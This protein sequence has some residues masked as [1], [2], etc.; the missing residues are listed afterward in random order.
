MN[1]AE[2]KPDFE[3]AVS[4]LRQ[5]LT[6]IT[7]G[8]ADPSLLER[9]TVTAYDASMKLQEVA[10]ITV[11]EPRVL[12]IEPW[13]KSLVKDIG[14]ALKAANLDGQIQISGDGIRFIIPQMTEESRK[15]YVK[16]VGEKVEKARIAVR[17]VRDKIKEKINKE[18]KTKEISED[19]KFTQLKQ[20]DELAGEY[21]AQIKDIGDQKTK[22]I[23][24][25]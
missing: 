23:L 20:L 16:S 17:Q 3:H 8:R 9:V 13:D 25:I 15:V 21:N 19:D 14:G 7:T 5:D 4:F 10:S 24:T 11:P 22:E 6:E 1:I 18:A 12:L 2:A